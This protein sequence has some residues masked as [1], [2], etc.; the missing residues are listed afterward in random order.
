MSTYDSPT[1]AKK[2]TLKDNGF[3]IEPQQLESPTLVKEFLDMRE[4]TIEDVWEGSNMRLVDMISQT[5]S[6][7]EVVM[8]DIRR[9]ASESSLMTSPPTLRRYS[10]AWSEDLGE[11]SLDSLQ[12]ELV[13]KQCMSLLRSH[14]FCLA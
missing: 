2:V 6:E 10:S 11:L 8:G 1:A 5:F 9:E 7:I 12:K 14:T 13:S 3:S 4:D